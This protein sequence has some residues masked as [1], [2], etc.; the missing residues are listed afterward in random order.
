MTEV[1]FMNR[2]RGLTPLQMRD[3]GIAPLSV[4]SDSTAGNL[5][6]VVCLLIGFVLMMAGSFYRQLSLWS[7]GFLCGGGIV[8]YL[9][10]FIFNNLPE[11]YS[12]V[13]LGLVPLG[14]GVV[15]AI[16]MLKILGEE[17]VFEL[18]GAIAGFVAGYF[19]YTL[20]A[21]A[22]PAPA[23]AAQLAQ[24]FPCLLQ[25]SPTTSLRAGRSGVLS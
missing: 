25:P 2:W 24:V 15:S 12:C 17:K 21:C 20:G 7:L 18:L 23:A 9:V 22:C 16:Y 8:F 11:L 5:F 10:S 14:A 19:V 3:Q 13:L 6:H 4:F 1:C